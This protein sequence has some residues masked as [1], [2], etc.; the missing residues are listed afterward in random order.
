VILAT[1]YILFFYSERVFWSF[2]RPGGKLL[3]LVLGW[4]VC[5]M[6]LQ[7]SDRLCVQFHFAPAS[8]PIP[9]LNWDTSSPLIS[10]VAI[11]RRIQPYG[12]RV[13]DLDNLLPVASQ[14]S[15]LAVTP[16]AKDLPIS[17]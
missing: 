9:L 5:R 2:L 15:P 16:S 17:L 14:A 1:G 4:F 11:A 13:D 10:D 8:G 7:S 12:H 6:H 3:D